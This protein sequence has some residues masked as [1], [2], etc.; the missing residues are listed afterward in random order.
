MRGRM[1]GRREAG[2]A[3]GGS[4]NGIGSRDMVEA[5][6]RNQGASEYNLLLP[7]DL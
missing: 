1:R 3:G 6:V 7:M 5:L 2:R 4:G